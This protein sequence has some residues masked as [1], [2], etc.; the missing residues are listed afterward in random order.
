MFGLTVQCGTDHGVIIVGDHQVLVDKPLAIDIHQMG[1]RT[2]EDHLAHHV[3]GDICSDVKRG[4]QGI[5]QGTS[6]FGHHI[7]VAADPGMAGGDLRLFKVFLRIEFFAQFLIGGNGAGSHNDRLCSNAQF[8]LLLGGHHADDLPLTI[9]DKAP[10][11]G[12]HHK[13]NAGIFALP[14]QHIGDHPSGDRNV[15]ILADGVGGE[16]AGTGGGADVVELD[17]LFALQPLDH[18]SGLVDKISGQPGVAGP[19]GRLHVPGEHL[20]FGGSDALALH[21]FAFYTEHMADDSAGAAY[22]FAPF[23]HHHLFCPRLHSRQ[24]CRQSGTACSNY[25]NVS[26]KI[27]RRHAVT[28]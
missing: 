9:F 1:I 11:A 20:V 28:S 17:T 16:I 18:V 7:A 6:L 21:R 14:G 8:L 3:T 27:E 22:H 12:A 26:L 15:V 2:A 19:V 23:Q 13:L 24:G 5:T 10:D 25:Q 4:H